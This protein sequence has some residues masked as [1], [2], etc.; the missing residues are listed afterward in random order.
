MNKRAI[1]RNQPI[2][3]HHQAP[4]APQPGKGALDFIPATVAP[5][6]ATVLQLWYRAIP[7]MRT[8]QIDAEFLQ[9]LSQRVTIIPDL[10]LNF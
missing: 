3:A 10:H 1:H 6:L 4:E 2:V 5:E 7:P 9:P 8:N